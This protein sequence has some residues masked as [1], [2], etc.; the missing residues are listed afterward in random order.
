MSNSSFKPSSFETLYL[1]Y[2]KNLCPSS[3][4]RP[5]SVDVVRILPAIALNS[6]GTNSA[7]A[8][9]YCV[10]ESARQDT[11]AVQ[12][13][14][15][16]FSQNTAA[17]HSEHS[18]SSVRT[19]LR[20]SQNTAAVQSEHSCGSVRIMSRFSQNTVA[21]QSEHSSGCQYTVAV[22]S[23]HSCGSISTQL[24]FSQNTVAVQSAQ[25]RGSISTQLR[26][27]QHTF[28]VDFSVCELAFRLLL[29]IENISTCAKFTFSI[30]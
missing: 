14:Q 2:F 4:R 3:F 30:A 27:S 7:V 25:S 19:Q 23:A 13:E 6:D 12:S 17:V 26:F 8:V 15:L 1:R 24:R 18:C 20:F 9:Q 11:V 5:N 10:C 21:V 22:Q 29:I 16:R 28:A